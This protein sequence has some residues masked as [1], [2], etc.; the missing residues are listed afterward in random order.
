[1]KR[2]ILV[3][4]VA[5]LILNLFQ[6]NIFAA[7]ENYT[8][9]YIDILRSFNILLGDQNRSLSPNEDV[10]RS[11]F[12]T[13]VV[14]MNNIEPISK[15]S[16]FDDVPNDH[17]A[18]DFIVTATSLGYMMGNAR[19]FGANESISYDDAIKA[20]LKALGYPFGENDY[21]NIANQ[22]GLLRGVSAGP[23]SFA[24]RKNIARLIYNSINAELL[25][26][27]ST[28]KNT[29]GGS[30]K[31][32]IN[33]VY[34]LEKIS[35]IVYGYEKNS[36]DKELD[37][38]YALIGSYNVMTDF[39]LTDYV[40]YNVQCY[41]KVNEEN[42]YSLVWIK[43]INNGSESISCFDLKNDEISKEKI[44]FISKN[45][46]T[47]KF[48]LDANSKLIYNRRLVD[49]W[50]KEDLLFTDSYGNLEVI[51]NNNDGKYDVIKKNS[52]YDFPVSGKDRNSNKIS[53]LNGKVIEL[54]EYDEVKISKEGK[55]ARLS[56][57]KYNDI[58]SV[59]E[60]KNKKDLLIIISDKKAVGE[61]VESMDDVIV[62]EGIPY[63]FSETFYSQIGEKNVL[64]P[65]LGNFYKI[66]LN[67]MNMIGWVTEAQRMAAD[68][69][70]IYPYAVLTDV[71]SE[72]GLKDM[73][74]VKVK[75]FTA[76]GI[77]LILSCNKN[78]YIDNIKY[79]NADDILIKL[80]PIIKQLI[81][82][83]INQS[84]QIV[85]I[86][87][88]IESDEPA[89][90]DSLHYNGSGAFDYNGIQ[91]D[92]FSNSK[93]LTPYV[94][95]FRIVSSEGKVDTNRSLVTN[96]SYFSQDNWYTVHFYDQ[97]EVGIPG[98]VVILENL[99]DIKEVDKNSLIALGLSRGIKNDEECFY[100]NAYFKGEKK[101][102][103]LTRTVYDQIISENYA[104]PHIRSVYFDIDGN[105]SRSN[106]YIDF[107]EVNAG[108]KF[109]TED[110]MSYAGKIT[111]KIDNYFCLTMGTEKAYFII[112]NTP[113]IYTYNSNTNSVNVSD[114]GEL[115]L[116]SKVIIN[117]N[118]DFLR[119]IIIVN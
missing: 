47:E 60:D 23:S 69:N 106:K 119:D 54:N 78:V 95:I 64:L 62:I 105:I 42:E 20:I 34:K 110:R 90:P 6:L 38:N 59:S 12:S 73:S 50:N 75:L 115:L 35:G 8:D 117:T 83:E 9:D 74:K 41:I 113:Y 29:E 57:I 58:L 67:F 2:I 80:R 13:I 103:Q 37:N 85:K 33:D 99:E 3:I 17:W 27:Y 86:Y 10:T 71:A 40:G 88:R 4:I 22:I 116:N 109:Y 14:R 98:A 49:N 19:F 108:R 55:N 61:V 76:D 112:K 97:N 93:I 52:Y 21:F 94:P 45:D 82:Y 72:S 48:V 44:C 5:S 91:R 30:K 1:M 51:D 118:D 11:E 101:K 46:K 31:T 36:L 77:E 53:G 89:N 68:G 15:Q 43:K 87:T 18:K 104:F 96:M 25:E 28:N 24:K 39:D 92:G 70:I 102:L 26:L 16:F 63:R 32:L 100:L 66:H 114:A 84:G 7:G 81:K 79:N 107:Y 65:K 111:G 56:E